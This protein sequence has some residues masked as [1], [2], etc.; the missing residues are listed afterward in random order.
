MRVSF[1]WKEIHFPGGLKVKWL[2]NSDIV[3]YLLKASGCK[4]EIKKLNFVSFVVWRALIAGGWVGG[5]WWHGAK[6]LA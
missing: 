2:F 3:N 1:R 5:W 4:G 6:S